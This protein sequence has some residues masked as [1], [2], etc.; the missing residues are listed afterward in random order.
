MTNEEFMLEVEASI[1][2]AKKTLAYKA[3]VYAPHNDRLENFKCAASVQGINPIQALVGM[4]TKHYVSV[5][6]MSKNPLYFDLK[7]W[8][9]KLGDLR[10]Y[11]LLCEALI[12]DIGVS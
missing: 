2:R 5:C 1:N 6:E 9:E 8:N 10:N 7:V 11:V 4:M 3:S 12:R